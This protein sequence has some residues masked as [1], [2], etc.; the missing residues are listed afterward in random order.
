MK[1]QKDHEEQM[2][3]YK[4]L[5]S[6]SGIYKKRIQDQWDMYCNLKYFLL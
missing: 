4:K 3:K 6:E 2:E 5:E 1:S